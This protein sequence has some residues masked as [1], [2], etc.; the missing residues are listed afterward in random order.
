MTNMAKLGKKK[1]TDADIGRGTSNQTHIGLIESACI[2]QTGHATATL[3]YNGTTYPDLALLLGY[4]ENPD[5]SLRSPKI[6]KGSD[7]ELD[8][9]GLRSSVY[10]KIKRIVDTN[11]RIKYWGLKW[12][13]SNTGQYSFILENEVE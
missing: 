13:V 7:H 1:L 8:S 2:P 6:R 11:Q 9:M 4:I 12:R 3:S 5:G 10:R